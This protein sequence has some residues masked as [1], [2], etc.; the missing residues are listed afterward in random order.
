MSGVSD[1]ERE[2]LARGFAAYAEEMIKSVNR[3]LVLTLGGIAAAAHVYEY[4]SE[5]VRDL[6]QCAADGEC[7][8]CD[9]AEEEARLRKNLFL[10]VKNEDPQGSVS[11]AGETRPDAP[12]R[13]P[14]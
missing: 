6:I 3:S 7:P 2:D 1:E 10:I 13:R 11:G 8:R 12:E 9:Q 4:L 5:E 14:S